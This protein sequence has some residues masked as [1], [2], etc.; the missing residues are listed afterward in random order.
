[1]NIYSDSSYSAIKYLKDTE[2]NLRN[3]LIMTG[4]FNIHN[5]LWDLSYSHY[6]SISDHLF[7][8]ANSFNLSLSYPTDQAPTRYSNNANDS[9]LVIDLIFL[10]CDSLELNTHLIHPEWY[11]T[12]NYA[13]LMIII[14]IVEEHIVTHKRT[15]TKNSDEEVKFINKVIAF[16]A[17]VDVLNVVNISELEEAISN[18]ANIIDCSWTKYS[19]LVNI[20]KHSK[21]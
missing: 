18:F 3:L 13:P 15:I 4:D 11:L 14:P 10:Q 9:N 16:F 2:C 8:I 5:S 21:S 7:A 20:T 6:S 19:K 17:K 12:S 1:M